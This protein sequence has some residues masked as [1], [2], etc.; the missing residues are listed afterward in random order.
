MRINSDK[1]CFLYHNFDDTCLND[2]RAALPY[3]MLPIQSGITYLGYQ[4]KPLNYRV[5]DWFWLLQKFE[6]RINHW[7][8]KYLSLGGRLV[9]VNAVLSSIP[10][11]WMGLAPL[12]C[13]I[14]KKLRRSLFNFLWGS[15][16]SSFKYH[17]SIWNDLSRP[18]YYGGWG[19]KNL[20]GSIKLCG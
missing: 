1:S 16:E 12:P 11:Y 14:L 10:V 2:F 19:I 18:K 3:K 5:A 13:T 20:P 6:K 9:L 15:T 4:L 7:A 17:L 8:Y